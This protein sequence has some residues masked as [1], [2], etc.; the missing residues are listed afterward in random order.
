M[1]GDDQKAPK[2]YEKFRDQLPPRPLTPEEDRDL[3]LRIGLSLTHAERFEWL[4][5]TV[6]ALRPLL[7][8]ARQAERPGSLEEPPGD[9]GA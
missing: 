3:Q 1:K 7:G 9:P 6:E 4:C 2:G 5:R 8:K